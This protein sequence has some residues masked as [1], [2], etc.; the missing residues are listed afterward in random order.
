M[1]WRAGLSGDELAV[2]NRIR[3]LP[4]GMQAEWVGVEIHRHQHTPMWRRAGG[5]GL[6]GGV[7]LAALQGIEWL[8]DVL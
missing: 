3:D 6:G 4:P 8:K 5:T 7:L 1:A 2:A